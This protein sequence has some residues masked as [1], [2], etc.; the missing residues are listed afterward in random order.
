[1]ELAAEIHIGIIHPEL[2]AVEFHQTPGD[3]KS[4]S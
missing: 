3:R 2:S 1:M 4:K